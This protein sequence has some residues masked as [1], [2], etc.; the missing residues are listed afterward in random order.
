M[1][2]STRQCK[3]NCTCGYCKKRYQLPL[4]FFL[5]GI[6][7]I[8]SVLQC[9]YKLRAI[10]I[11]LFRI[12]SSAF[13]YNSFQ[14]SG[15]FRAILPNRCIFISWSTRILPC[16]QMMHCHSKRIN[17]RACVCLTASILFW[18]TISFCSEHCCVRQTLFFVFS[19]N[20]EVKYFQISFRL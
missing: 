16:Q 8:R 3:H 2:R 6:F 20:A 10:L 13:I 14:T 5:I 1:Q 19:C 18:R 11:P 7:I 17:I 4:L 9:K 15:Q 12:Q